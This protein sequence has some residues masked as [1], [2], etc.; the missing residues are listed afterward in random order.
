MKRIL[1]L[2]AACLPVLF[3]ACQTEGGG[4]GDAATADVP[5]VQTPTAPPSSSSPASKP[6]A[7]AEAPPR[8]PSDWVPV[9]IVIDD[10][11][12][13][14]GAALAGDDLE[15]FALNAFPPMLPGSDHHAGAWT[16][17]DCMLCH[18][19]GVLGAPI[20][21]HRGMTRL[22]LQSNCRT[23]HVAADPD[24][25]PLTNLAG[26]EVQVF[27]ANAF[28]PTL[29]VDE[30]HA[31]AWLRTDC[32]QCHQWGSAQAPK[33]RHHGMSKLLLKANCRSCHVPGANSALTDVP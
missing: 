11:V 27:L 6:A 16:R 3:V 25:G 29:P 22:L 24:A 15:G 19:E 13:I 21:R 12:K 10:A 8:S 26:E 2:S 1:I 17:T 4:Q 14:E 33:V 20:V 18:E 5:V 31:A 9:A 30:S 7:L 23:C 32:L 28:P